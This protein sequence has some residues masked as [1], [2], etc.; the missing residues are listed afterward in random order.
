MPVK[1]WLL[2]PCVTAFYAMIWIGFL[3]FQTYSLHTFLGLE[4]FVSRDQVQRTPDLTD[5][6]VNKENI[7]PTNSLEDK[8]PISNEEQPENI[9][10]NY[11]NEISQDYRR[12]RDD[13]PNADGDTKQSSLMEQRS[14]YNSGLFEDILGPELEEE[15][16]NEG[17]DRSQEELV[18]IDRSHNIIKGEIRKISYFIAMKDKGKV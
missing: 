9:Y 17:S 18:V 12:L 6:E 1:T 8:S 15:Y 5:D 11:L 10:N 2:I 3:N 14:G 7:T 13:L 4:A 16:D